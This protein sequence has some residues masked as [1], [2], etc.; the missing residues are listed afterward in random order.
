MSL[1]HAGTNWKS[2]SYRFLVSILPTYNRSFD[3]KNLGM[4]FCFLGLVE[5]LLSFQFSFFIVKEECKRNN[6][7]CFLYSV[8]YDFCFTAQTRET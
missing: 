7:R 6:F 3:K 8:K 1:G 5:G 2:K 4:L